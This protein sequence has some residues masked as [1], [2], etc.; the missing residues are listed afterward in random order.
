MLGSTQAIISK[1][2]CSL[3]LS[4][5]VTPSLSHVASSFV[6]HMQHVSGASGGSKWFKRSTHIFPSGCHCLAAH[7]RHLFIR[8]FWHGFGFDVSI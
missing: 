2:V 8:S 1:I 6:L 5:Y 4:L 3:T 7:T